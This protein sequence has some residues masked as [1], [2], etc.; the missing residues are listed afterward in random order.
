MIRVRDQMIVSW[1]LSSIICLFSEN[2]SS[3]SLTVKSRSPDSHNKI[4]P[5]PLYNRPNIGLSSCR[6]K[7]LTSNSLT[8]LPSIVVH[9]D[10]NEF[11]THRPLVRRMSLPSE[12]RSRVNSDVSHDK[13][14]LEKRLSEK[15]TLSISDDNDVPVFRDSLTPTPVPQAYRT[16]V[17]GGVVTRI[18]ILSER[19]KKSS[20]MPKKSKGRLWKS[21]SFRRSEQNINLVQK[22]S[23]TLSPLTES[24]QIKIINGVPHKFPPRA[25]VESK[26]KQKRS[27]KGKRA[28]NN[29]GSHSNLHISHS[30]ESFPTCA[31]LSLHNGYSD[32]HVET[33]QTASLSSTEIL[34]PVRTNSPNLQGKFIH[35]V[36]SNGQIEVELISEINDTLD[37]IAFENIPEELKVPCN[38]IRNPDC[39]GWLTKLGGTGLTPRNWRKR[40]FVL[41]GADLYYYKSSFDFYALGKIYVPK[42]AIDIDTEIKKKHSFC[43]YHPLTRTY[44]MFADTEA[45]AQKWILSLS[46]QSQPAFSTPARLSS[47]SIES[48]K[49]WKSK[50]SQMSND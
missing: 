1:E 24:Y 16:L 32:R 22:P 15:L 34:S 29:L 25:L 10:I 38:T 12:K 37:T 40:W 27:E 7:E 21:I 14:P 3:L 46:K 2:Q 20:T 35:R 45:D 36:T 23:D 47:P 19:D 50:D 17:V 33:K 4:P 11:R 39:V 9:S 30:L 26:K 18:P 5:I 41:K 13:R 6:N 42:Y 8:C 44:C 28:P 48:M 43:L 49:D 31:E